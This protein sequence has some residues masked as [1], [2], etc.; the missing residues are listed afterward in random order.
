MGHRDGVP[1]GS[2]P[3][4]DELLRDGKLLELV[5]LVL[6]GHDDVELG[7]LGRDDLGI[8]RIVSFSTPGRGNLSSKEATVKSI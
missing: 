1:L 8:E 7:R 3:L 4:G 6:A 5:A 2:V